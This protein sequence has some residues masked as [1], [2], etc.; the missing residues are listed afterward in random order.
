MSA[1][2]NEPF[3]YERGRQAGLA[4][5]ERL[6]YDAGSL[7]E[8]MRM[9]RILKRYMTAD[10]KLIWHADRDMTRDELNELIDGGEG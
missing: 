8:R 1:V 5:G 4:W 10:G 7:A 9:K 2:E 6:G 3:A